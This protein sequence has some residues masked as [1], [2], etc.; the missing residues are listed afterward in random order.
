MSIDDATNIPGSDLYL[1]KY[2]ADWW[3]VK[4]YGQSPTFGVPEGTLEE[5]RE[6]AEAMIAG[7]K[8]KC[9]RLAYKDGRVWSPRNTNRIEDR[10]SVSDPV[11]VGKWLLER[12]ESAKKEA[13]K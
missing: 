5:W 7:T 2:D 12:I 1:D 9:K 13:G 3:G 6:T 10:I 4:R 8:S 11:A